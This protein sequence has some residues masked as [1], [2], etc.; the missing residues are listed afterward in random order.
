MFASTQNLIFFFK[1]MIEPNDLV[2]PTDFAGPL[3]EVG[4]T[5][6]GTPSAEVTEVADNIVD[7]NIDR[8]LECEY[9][10]DQNRDSPFLTL[11]LFLSR[12]TSNASQAFPL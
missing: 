8:I 9:V 2:Q 1:G 10:K 5:Q 4:L 7:A 11:S 12:K 3:A 6:V